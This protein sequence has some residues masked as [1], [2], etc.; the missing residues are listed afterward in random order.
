MGPDT[1][2]VATETGAVGGGRPLTEVQALGVAGSRPA[3]VS[4]LYSPRRRPRAEGL[5]GGGPSLRRPPSEGRQW[6]QAA[7]QAPGQGAPALGLSL[8]QT[9]QE[10]CGMTSGRPQA[11]GDWFPLLS[12]QGTPP[13]SSPAFRPSW[14][15]WPPRQGHRVRQWHVRASPPR[16]EVSSWGIGVGWG[17]GRRCQGQVGASGAMSE[18]TCR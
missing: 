9:P 14:E 16:G 2:S 10:G 6:D 12:P 5:H 3:A 17:Q 8:R 4:G 7:G 15:W 13:T 18:V 11:L 1:R